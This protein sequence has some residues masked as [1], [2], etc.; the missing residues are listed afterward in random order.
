MVHVLNFTY[1]LYTLSDTLQSWE[2]YWVKKWL[3]YRMSIT[4]TWHRS[5]PE[6]SI[7]CAC[8]T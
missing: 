8:K 3:V 6:P 5:A 4:G 1:P 2:L 7:M